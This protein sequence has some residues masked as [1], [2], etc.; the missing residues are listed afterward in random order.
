MGIEQ[1]INQKLNEH[2][3]LKK[4]IKK[5][6]QR[7]MYAI[8]PK[9]KLEGD[10][11]RVSPDDLKHEYFFG[12]YDKSP[13]DATDR[14]MLCMKAND[15]WSDVSPKEIAKII[16][17]DT[18]HD[19]KVVTL[20]ETHSWNVQQG[21][22]L[23]WVGPEYKDRILFNDCRNGQYCSVILKLEFPKNGNL[24]N[25]KVTEEKVI[26]APVYSVASDGTFALTLDFSRLYRL[27]PGYGYYNVPEETADEKLPDKPCIWYVNLITGEVKPI[28]K[29]TDFANFQPRPEMEGAEHKVNHIM[30]S[31]NGKRFMVLYRWFTGQRKYTRLITCNVDGT[32][33]YILSD[34]DMVSH[35]CWRTDKQIFA[36]E[37]K[38]HGLKGDKVGNGYYLMKDKTQEYRRFWPGIDYDGH[39]SYS[40]DGSKIVFDRYPDR[41]RITEIMVSDAKNRKN[42]GVKTIAR[43]FAPF[44]YDNDTRCDLHPRW[45]RAGDKVCFD[46]VFEGH[47]GLYVIDVDTINSNRN[48]LSNSEADNGEKI[49]RKVC[50]L[51]STYNGEKYLEEQ[52][53]S[54]LQQEGV[55]I[56]IL[57]RDDGSN[58]S[59]VHILDQ[60]QKADDRF[61]Y[62]VGKNVGPAKS[63]F[64][65]II[66]AGEADYYAF[67]DQDDVWDNDKLKVAVD[68][69]ELEDNSKPN[70]YYSNLR[71]VD[72][73]LKF[74][75]LSHETPSVQQSKYSCLTEDMATGCTVVFNKKTVEYVRTGTPE[76]CSMHDTWIYLICKFF[77]K[78]VYDF[79]AHI[80]YRQHGNNVVGTYLG[81]K[82]FDIYVK[83]VK[84]L[85]DREL[86]PRYNNAKNFYKIFGE[87]LTDED[88]EKVKEII[89]YKD[90][91]SKKL[92]LLGDKSIHASSK[93]R[94]IR[95]R[96]LIL[97]G[98][99]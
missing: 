65:L 87:K 46:S 85:F 88:A 25:L 9:I 60:Y 55:D 14:Y 5:V 51:L 73:N 19:N 30:L 48:C 20:A 15:T 63:F 98:I 80:S 16:L 89:E 40:P 74:Y 61:H 99:V 96:L 62:Y 82:T 3:I 13:W 93:S 43:M 56:S 12:Y 97:C 83:R 64:D 37:N 90:S 59:T 84:R 44:K 17:I 77:G 31:P 41:A 66:Q 67:S 39:P 94:E 54:L 45:N 79:D 52:I 92:Q 70:M 53:D 23:Q 95:Y 8:S 57:A 11:V 27:R 71:I 50:I 49:R 35:C 38:K 72:Q 58:D 76:Y 34:D 2:P 81:K 78:T 21:C 4:K 36:F 7:T 10:V 42:S 47:R 86:Q 29:Y 28:L 32:D 18:K 6:Y 69:L 26:P 33:M 91:I 68:R 75:R 22:M 1:I 24:D